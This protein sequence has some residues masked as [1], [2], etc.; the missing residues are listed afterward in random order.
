MESGWLEFENSIFERLTGDGSVPTRKI[1]VE[2]W[3]G[4]DVKREGGKRK[5]LY[6]FCRGILILWLYRFFFL[7][8]EVDVLCGLRVPSKL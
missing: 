4:G 1:W 2:K 8:L 5:R 7:L 3:R 6:R